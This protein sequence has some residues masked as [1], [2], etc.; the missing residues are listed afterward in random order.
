MT[1]F[2]VFLRGVNIG[3]HNR[4]PMAEFRE[5]LAVAGLPEARTYIQ[6]GNLLV[7]SGPSQSQ[8]S[9]VVGQV[10]VEVFSLSVAFCVVAQDRLERVVAFASAQSDDLDPAR[11]GVVFFDGAVAGVPEDLATYLPER[12]LVESDFALW[13]CPDG[14]GRA[15]ITQSK[16]DRWLNKTATVRNLKTALAVSKLLA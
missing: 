2:A 13:L 6:S 1:G 16:L 4:L 8:V 10:L 14:F 11:V 5:A 3:G 15:K 9:R 12:L 7:A